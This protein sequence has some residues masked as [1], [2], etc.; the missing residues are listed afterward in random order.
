MPTITITWS[1]DGR[2]DLSEF[3]IAIP[4]LPNRSNQILEALHTKG[5][6]NSSEREVFRCL[7]SRPIELDL[8]ALAHSRQYAAAV[9]GSD[10]AAKVAECYELFDA[11]GRPNRYSP[12]A[13]KRPLSDLALYQ[14]KEADLTLQSARIALNTGFAYLL[15]GGMHHASAQHGRGFCLINDVVIAARWLQQN[16]AVR[17]VWVIDNDAHK[18]DG[19]AAICQD[20]PSI[21]TLSI[22]M[23]QGWPLDEPVALA[24]GTP[25]PAHAPSNIDIGI[26]RGEES[27]YVAQLRAGLAKLRADYPRPD[28]V[29]VVNG[30]DPYVADE[31]PSTQPLQLTL[32]QML[33]R[34]RLVYEF[35]LQ[36]DAPQLWLMAGGYGREVWRPHANF[37]ES[38]LQESGG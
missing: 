20:D 3:G 22:H 32:E 4:L 11:R 8:I 14:R 37:L 27:S 23:A 28:F 36:L 35:L 17:T 38:V 5:F 30:S 29:I 12:Q 15:G 1:E 19:T 18:G 10:A 24:D 6:R 13:A 21:I 34:D 9:C 26:E 16:T 25:S 7:K 33:E 2:A 31:L